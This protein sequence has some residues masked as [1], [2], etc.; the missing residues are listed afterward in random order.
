MSVSDTTRK[1]GVGS[2]MI[3]VLENWGREKG[4]KF[5][6]LSTLK[7]MHLAVQLY[8]RNGYTLDSEEDHDVSAM[9]N[10]AEPI[11]L[12]IYNYSKPIV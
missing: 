1:M 4:Y 2:K 6:N 8:T 7:K 5:V 12:T 11:L 10:S 9:F 3:S